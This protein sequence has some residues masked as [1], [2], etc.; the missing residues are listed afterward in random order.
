MLHQFV[1]QIHYRVSGA[2]RNS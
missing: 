1:L 2:A